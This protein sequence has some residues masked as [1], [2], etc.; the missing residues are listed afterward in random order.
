MRHCTAAR[1]GAEEQCR[2]GCSAASAG[3]GRS[4]HVVTTNRHL[5][6][7]DPREAPVRHV[8]ML[9]RSKPPGHLAT[10]ST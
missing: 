3:G 1:R 4:S 5:L 8:T 7:N 10:S 6:E 2:Y 9:V